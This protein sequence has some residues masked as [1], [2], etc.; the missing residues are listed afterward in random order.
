MDPT[1]QILEA[2]AALRL[3]L[4][5]IRREVGDLGKDLRDE[6]GG[7]ATAQSDLKSRVASIEA[8]QSSQKERWPEVLKRIDGGDGRLGE[9]ERAVAKWSGIAIVVSTLL[10]LVLSRAAELFAR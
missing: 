7:V 4:S 10:S 5:T 8:W 1:Q 3:D 2:I 9:L 6:I